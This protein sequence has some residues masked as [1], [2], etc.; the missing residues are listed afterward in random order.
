MGAIK[1]WLDTNDAVG[2]RPLEIQWR[3]AEELHA[4]LGAP[5]YEPRPEPIRE[6]LKNVHAVVTTPSTLQLE[7]AVTGLPVAVVDFHNSPQMTPMAW[8]IAH[9]SQ[10]GDVILELASPPPGKQFTQDVLLNDGLQF[11]QPAGPRMIQLISQMIQSGNEARQANRPIELPS[12]IL[13]EPGDGFSKEQPSGARSRLFPD[14]PVFSDEDVEHLQTEL[15]AAVHEMG[16]YPEKYFQQRTINQKLRSYVNWLRLLIRNRASTVEEL[17]REIQ[18]LKNDRSGQRRVKP[19]KFRVTLDTRVSPIMRTYDPAQP[20]IFMHM[21]KCAG[22]SFIRLLRQW[23][24]DQYHKLNQD[25][26]RDILL[27]RIQTRDEDGNWLPDVKCIHGHFDNG[28]GYGLP[29]FYPEINQYFTVLRDP[30]DIAVS[31]FFFCKKRSAEGK[32]WYRGRQEN[33]LDKYPDVEYYL[34]ECPYWIYNHLPQDL[35]LQNYQRR[36]EERFFYIGIQEDIET[37]IRQLAKNTWQTGRRS[38]TV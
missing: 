21:P 26:T 27:P 25:E 35:T 19:C 11:E 38:R 9:E 15:A 2:D 16:N 7:A 31:M 6:T 33:I 13:P 17:S 36:L 28:R 5:G 12:R 22:S 30:F 34:K 18:T 32:F 3:M 8:Q 20:A 14:N 37:S 23:F 10:I 24:G 29:Y 1:Q 4:N